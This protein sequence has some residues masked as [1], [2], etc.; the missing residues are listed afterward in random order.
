MSDNKR[1]LVEEFFR[2][3]CNGRKLALADNLFS[4]DHE[5]HD[6]TSPWVG[7]G[8]QGMKDLISAYQTG[9]PDAHWSIE[10]IL[11]AGDVVITRWTGRGTHKR[12]LM[13]IAPMGKSVI[14]QG[15]WIHKVDGDRI[16]QSWNIWDALGMMQQLGVVPG[17]QASQ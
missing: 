7:R 13:G 11:V 16:V 1:T 5:Y 9:F 10:E 12:E 6:P 3:V 2:E 14:V 4:P 15:I 8:P 17:F